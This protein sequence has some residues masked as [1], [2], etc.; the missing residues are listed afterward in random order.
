[1][2]FLLAVDESKNGE[3][4]AEYVGTLFRRT[5]DVTLTLFHVLKPMPRKLLEHGGS[6]DPNVEGRLQTQLRQEQTEWSRAQREAECPYLHKAREVLIKAGLSPQGIE[7]KFG[8]EEDIARNILE[9]A[10]TGG[11]ET[12]VL[13]RYGPS[14]MKRI[15]GGGITEHVLREAT[16]LAVW[17]IE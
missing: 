16:G 14:G 8:Y 5:P 12:I 15:F 2:K 3:R 1:M 10:R 7:M 13:G 9:E 17:I 4:M 6:E 11:H